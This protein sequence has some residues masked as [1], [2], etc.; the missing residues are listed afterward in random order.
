MTFLQFGI[1]SLQISFQEPNAVWRQA[2]SKYH[3]G[4]THTFFFE[5]TI[6]PFPANNLHI[7]WGY[8]LNT[9]CRFV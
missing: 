3:T 9:A 4:V 1:V 2:A 6:L 7:F 5:P 8:F